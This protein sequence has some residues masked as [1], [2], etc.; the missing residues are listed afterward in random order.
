MGLPSKA[1]VAR[2]ALHRLASETGGRAFFV[3][4]NDDLSEVYRSI[5]REL[6]S[7]YLLAYQSSATGEG[8]R[9]VEVEV[10]RPGVSAATVRGYYP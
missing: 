10:D 5:E 1:D 2:A 4:R 3:S 6:R 7:Q 9:R 8:F